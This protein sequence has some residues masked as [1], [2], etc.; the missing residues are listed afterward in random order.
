MSITFRFTWPKPAGFDALELSMA[1]NPHN[2][3]TA[4]GEP[5]C[6]PRDPGKL[7]KCNL[8]SNDPVEFIALGP[9]ET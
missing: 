1:H 2:D 6:L 3:L 8:G 7:R 9:R 4:R 5:R